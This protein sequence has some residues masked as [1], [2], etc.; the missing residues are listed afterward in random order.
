MHKIGKEFK[1]FGPITK[2]TTDANAVHL[3]PPPAYVICVFVGRA[4]KGSG[5]FRGTA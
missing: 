1:S 5:S 3:S 2:N 4:T